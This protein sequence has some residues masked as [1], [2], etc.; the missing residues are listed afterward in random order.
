MRKTGGP[1]NS[2]HRGADGRR[3]SPGTPAIAGAYQGIDSEASEPDAKGNPS[4]G[5]PVGDDLFGEAAHEDGMPSLHQ[6]DRS[7]DDE[8]MV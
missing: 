2:G 1:Q 4:L 8:Q 5:D 3:P 7:D 6:E